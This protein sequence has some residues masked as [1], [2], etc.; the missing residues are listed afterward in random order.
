MSTLAAAKEAIAKHL[1]TLEAFQFAQDTLSRLASIENEEREA[2]ARLD[3][4]G[5]AA[6]RA[7]EQVARFKAEEAQLAA[8]REQDRLE[9]TR[10]AADI[11]AKAEETA[12]AVEKAAQ[13]T[14]ADLEAKANE[15]VANMVAK[16]E[17]A[18]RDA[19]ER[20]IKANLSAS[21]AESGEAK[22]LA[23]LADLTAKIESAK[24][25]IAKMLG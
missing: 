2:Q 14:I 20:A 23:E 15:R 3:S 4:I 24:A 10:R 11:I 21:A 1:K 25:T 7:Q 16:A 12:K 6:A 13:E 8:A 5:K 22:A 17:A 18:V 9:H 19:N